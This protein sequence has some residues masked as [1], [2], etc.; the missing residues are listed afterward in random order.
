MSRERRRADQLEGN[1]AIGRALQRAFSA[2]VGS[3]GGDRPVFML[4][5]DS[6]NNDFTTSDGSTFYVQP[7]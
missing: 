3:I 1:S 5:R 6:A 2:A 4:F 7:R